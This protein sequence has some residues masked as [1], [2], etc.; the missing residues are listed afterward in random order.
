MIATQLGGVWAAVPTPADDRFEPDAPK[1]IAYYGT[2][3]DGGC[4]GI[5]LL[6]TTG[7]AMSLSARQRLRLMEAVAGSGLPMDRV[8]VG[9]GAASLDDAATLTKRAFELG[10]RAALLMPPFFFRDAGD[11]GILRFFDTLFAR[12]APP[13]Q[14]V[15]LYHFP[16]MSGI[17]FHPQLV[18]RLIEAFPQTIAGLKDSANDPAL[19]AQLLA[20]HPALRVF[21]GSEGQLVSSAAYGAAGCIS[22]S[23][24]LWAPLAREVHRTHDPAKAA[25]LAAKRDAIARFPLGAAVRH[26]IAVT[27]ADPQWERPFPPLSPLDPATKA[28]L[29][30]AVE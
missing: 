26:R 25:A 12:A 30:A 11:D 19:Q 8:M 20:R 16:R 5:N 14:G 10:F 3:L 27:L 29:D 2:L 21:P 6:G 15:V 22:G 23:V 7:E 13:P 24:A 17:A 28:A 9:C 4:D 18:A 1:A